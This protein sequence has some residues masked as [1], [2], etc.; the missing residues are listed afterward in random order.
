MSIYVYIYIYIY[1]F[2]Q[3]PAARKQRKFT[4]KEPAVL[5]GSRCIQ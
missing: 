1:I 4:R 3:R 5:G 2:L